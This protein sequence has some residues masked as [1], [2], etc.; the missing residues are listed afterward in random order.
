MLRR[1]FS[2]CAVLGLVS[3]AQAGVIVTLVPSSVGPYQH[4]QVVTV[5]VLARIE[6]AV[7]APAPGNPDA[8]L[9][10]AQFDV[11]ASD[12]LLGIAPVVTHTIGEEPPFTDL[13][14]W[15]FSST[16]NCTTNPGACGTGYFI[17][18]SLSD[19]TPDILSL[20]FAQT[21]SS[22]LRQIALSTTDKRVGVLQ[23][24]MPDVDGTFLLDVLNSE[25]TGADSGAQFVHGFGNP[26][27]TPPADPT[28]TFTASGGGVV[29]A[30]GQENGLV[31]AVPEPA[32]LALL[33]M[34]GLAAA[35][36]RRRSA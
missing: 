21:T 8:R 19:A 36:R 15:D 34:G 25:A 6:T 18:G 14:F 11:G 16:S 12:P 7:P 20:A 10:L 28:I 2:L 13:T 30:V 1:A 22:G 31:F 32:T 5:D 35:F 3:T 17:D 33:G 4:G 27:P 24:T 29:M 9:R 23:I 26:G